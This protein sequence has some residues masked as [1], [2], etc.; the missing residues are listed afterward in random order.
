MLKQNNEVRTMAAWKRC[1]HLTKAS[2][3]RNLSVAAASP[4]GINYDPKQ[5]KLMLNDQCI[6]VDTSDNIIGSASK[7]ECHLSSN[8]YLHRAFSVLLFDSQNR[9]LMQQR[10]RHKITFPHYWTNSCCSHPLFIREHCEMVKDGN[11]QNDLLQMRINGVK[12]A[13]IKRLN[14]ELGIPLN[15]IAE[16]DDFNFVTRIL[17]KAL[18]DDTKWIE[19]ELDYI[20]II[21]KDV[22]LN[23]NENEVNDVK[24][25]NPVDLF[26]MVNDEKILI[27]PWFRILYGSGLI[28][29][30]W[31][32]LD[33]IFNKQYQIEE[34]I[35]DFYNH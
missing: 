23:L 33:E 1:T 34:Q 21:K 8:G 13:A 32:N 7:K 11:N 10:A 17:Y 35:R 26:A 27:S 9:L 19:H 3:T 5:M 16:V 30:W 22:A 28:N 12:N 24:Y 18:C 25:C 15:E 6:L 2:N 20:L 14:M 4:Q 29:E 31:S